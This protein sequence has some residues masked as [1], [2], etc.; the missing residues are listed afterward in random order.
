MDDDEEDDDRDDE[1]R[2]EYQPDSEQEEPGEGN[3]R[4]FAFFH[5]FCVYSVFFGQRPLV[6]LLLLLGPPF[7]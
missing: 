2:D 3:I 6:P 1:D 5:Y 7:L 4:V